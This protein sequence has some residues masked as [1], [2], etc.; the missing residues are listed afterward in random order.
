MIHKED[1][2]KCEH[3]KDGH[4]YWSKYC[5]AYVCDKCGH[6]KGMIGC[7]CGWNVKNLYDAGLSTYDIYG[8]DE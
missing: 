1:G 4:Y 3:C 5:A 2:T 8:D 6:H 7:Y